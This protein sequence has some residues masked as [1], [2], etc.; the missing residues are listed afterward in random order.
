MKWSCLLYVFD[1]HKFGCGV[2]FERPE[3]A[4]ALFFR[5]LG[6]GLQE[7]IIFLMFVR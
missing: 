7:R 1:L 5:C 4:I 6:G 3:V 2:E